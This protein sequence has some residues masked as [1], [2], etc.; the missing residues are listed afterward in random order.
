MEMINRWQCKLKAIIRSIPQFIMGNFPIDGHDWVDIEEHKN[1]TVT[2]SKCEI[3]GKTHVSWS[4]R[5]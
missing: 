2:I 5:H 1:C 3:C 4:Q